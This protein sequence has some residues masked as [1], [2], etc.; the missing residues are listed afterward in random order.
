MS[1]TLEPEVSPKGA[2]SNPEVKLV[3][4]GHLE[5]VG[6]PIAQPE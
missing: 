2:L 3:D 6:K 5:G 1:R 4:P